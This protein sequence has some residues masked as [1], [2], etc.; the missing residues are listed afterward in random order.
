MV[1]VSAD[2]PVDDGDA[3]ICCGC[4]CGGRSVTR[5]TC[6][7]GLVAYAAVLGILATILAATGPAAPW[8]VLEHWPNVTSAEN[9][10]DVTVD[11]FEQR[12]F[13]SGRVSIAPLCI[14]TSTARARVSRSS[15]WPSA[16]TETTSCFP[17]PAVPPA[18][19]DVSAVVPFA[20]VGEATL[21][22]V[23]VGTIATA[24][25]VGSL[26]ALLQCGPCRRNAC[27]RFQQAR[28]TSLWA[29]ASTLS[30]AGL[31]FLFASLATFNTGVADPMAAAA[32]H[33][34][35]LEDWTAYARRV[36]L[37]PWPP[38]LPAELVGVEVKRGAGY[39]ATAAGAGI[40]LIV[41]LFDLAVGCLGRKWLI[42]RPQYAAESA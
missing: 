42:C 13:L 30:V 17:L 16:S 20:A 40:L 14:T 10:T 25:A 37:G 19:L 31:G 36:G 8:L 18:A 3:P 27:Q 35:S 9:R 2:R 39:S 21:A 1:A 32:E 11:A 41:L 22:L 15:S 4:K 28:A 26:A 5:R 23:V 12:H 33:S 6:A 29:A 38:T 24:V 7:G 34:G